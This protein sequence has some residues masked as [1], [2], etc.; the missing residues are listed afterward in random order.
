MTVPNWTAATEAIDRANSILLVTHL[1]PDG[2]AIGSLLGL[3]NTLLARGKNPTLA[4]DGGVP[5]YL[6][7]LPGA[8]QVRD[9]L[10]QGEWDVMVLLDSSDEE[11][12]GEVGVYGRAHSRF[13]INLDHHPT[14]TMFGDLHLVVPTAVSA[15]EIVAAWI[16]AMPQEMT[17]DMALPLLTG[18][19]TDTMGFRTSNVRAET[20]GLAQRLMAA[21]ASLTEVMA[22]TLNNR[23]FST[24]ELWRS[25]MPSVVLED[26]LIMGT[27]TQE[28]LKR[29]RLTE[30][31]DGDLV[32]IL[33]SARE[34]MIAVVFKETNDGRVELSFRCKPG[35]DV[36]QVAFTLGGGGHKQAA[37]AT[38]PGTLDEAKARV[39]PML[40]AA[41]Q[42]GALVIA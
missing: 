12:T 16:D 36:S 33:I 17:K 2:D 37:G 29:A 14:N 31:T 30:T 20:L 13:V 7:F 10:K 32:S 27:I 4:V 6:Q 15:T 35:F 41:V 42:Q 21:G 5:D 39:I 19:V 3:A 11:R 25:A 1:S 22:R 18:L 8:A 28:D 38:I 34:A 9:K 26:S 40:R 23:P 24:L